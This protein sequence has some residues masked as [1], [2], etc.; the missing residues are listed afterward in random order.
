MQFEYVL[1]IIFVKWGLGTVTK[2][3]QHRQQ[4]ERLRD[5]VQYAVVLRNSKVPVTDAT[6]LLAS[7]SA[8][9]QKKLGAAN[10]QKKLRAADSKTA[11]G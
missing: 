10:D 4:R 8:S 6:D 3:I 11:P 1:L 9:D 2:L 5:A 7:Q